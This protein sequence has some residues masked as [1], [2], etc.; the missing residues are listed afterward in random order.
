MSSVPINENLILAAA[1][2]DRSGSMFSMGGSSEISGAV[3]KF[4]EDQYSHEVDG[5][6]V[7]SSLTTYDN[8]ISHVHEPSDDHITVM[9][10]DVE[11]RSLT[12]MNE[13]IGTTIEKIGEYLSNKTDERPGLVIVFI[14]T[15][16]DE[17]ASHGVWAGHR[18]TKKIKEMITQQKNVYN[19]QFMFAGANIDSVSVGDDL[20]IDASMCIDFHTSGDGCGAAIRSCS[21]ATSRLV[22]TDSEARVHFAGFTQ[23]ERDESACINSDGE[24]EIDNTSFDQQTYDDGNTYFVKAQRC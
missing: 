8:I 4:F 7:I 19:W 23:A 12:A 20:G 22:N 11:P 5:K 15:D 21:N 14:L 18:G 17:N 6:K 24:D 3:N 13:A 16:G 9:P 1:I 10:S 2:I